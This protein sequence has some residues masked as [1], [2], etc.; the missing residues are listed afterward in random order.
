MIFTT[1]ASESIHH[2]YSTVLAREV[3][4]RAGQCTLVAKIGYFFGNDRLGELACY[5]TERV[6]F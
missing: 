4:Y 1:T 6:Q 2:R 3:R 5:R